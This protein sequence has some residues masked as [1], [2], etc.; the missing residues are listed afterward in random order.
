MFCNIVGLG[1]V[2]LHIHCVVTVEPFFFDKN[3]Q[4]KLNAPLYLAQQCE[5]CLGSVVECLRDGRE[6]MVGVRSV[7]E[8]ENEFVAGGREGSVGHLYKRREGRGGGGEIARGSL[9]ININNG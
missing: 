8:C 6:R 9:T 4:D 5:N 7:C 3:L 1:E 2:H